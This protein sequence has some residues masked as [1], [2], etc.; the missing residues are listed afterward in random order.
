LNFLGN[1]IRG[2]GL[3]SSNI[4]V[5][6]YTIAPSN[7]SSYSGTCF[8]IGLYLVVRLLAY[9][10]YLAGPGLS[11]LIILGLSFILILVN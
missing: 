2:S 10:L 6:S 3:S 1:L 8:F 11:C 4:L 9:L 7:L 5:V